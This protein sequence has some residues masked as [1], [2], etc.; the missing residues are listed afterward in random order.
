MLLDEVDDGH[1]AV[2]LEEP[3]SRW[4]RVMNSLG[5]VWMTLGETV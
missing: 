2:V 5:L 4:T 1:W 3:V